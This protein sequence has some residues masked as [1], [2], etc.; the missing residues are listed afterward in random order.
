MKNFVIAAF[1]LIV[2][3]C[4]TD[5]VLPDADQLKKDVAIIDKYLAKNGIDAVKDPSGLRLVIQDL[6][7]GL[8]PDST[9]HLTVKYEGR[10]LNGT[11]FDKSKLTSTGSPEPFATPLYK[12]IRGW[13]IAFTY[14]GKGGKGTLYI[15]S[16][17]AY[18][19]AG[20]AGSPGVPGNAN[21]IFD[22]E[23]I[24]FTN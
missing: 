6:G 10:L 16:T 22:I 1:A 18:G 17:L 12:L 5:N 24:G 2:L 15:P 21:L 20:A 13:R 9:A 11:V 19:H 8:K 4:S 23:L 3:G 7:A 14:V